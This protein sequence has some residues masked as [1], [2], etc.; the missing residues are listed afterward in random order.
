MF[1]K[2]AFPIS[3]YQTFTYKIPGNLASDIRIGS[4]VMAPFGRKDVQGIVTWKKSTSSF[5]GKIKTISSIVDDIPVMTP[6]LWQLIEWMSQYYVAP[7]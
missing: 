2:V 4:R 6:E 5:K 7:I 3:G 1:A